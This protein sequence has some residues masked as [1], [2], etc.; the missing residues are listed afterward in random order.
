MIFDGVDLLAV[1]LDRRVGDH[2][3]GVERVLVG[4]RA[5]GRVDIVDQPFVQR[6]GVHAAFPVV[7]DGV[8]ETVDLGL[9]V[10]DARRL[11]GFAGG[12]ERLG[13]GLG[14]QRV[15]RLVERLGGR[16]RVLVSGERDVGIGRDHRLRIGVGG[17]R[18]RDERGASACRSQ[19][20]Q[21]SSRRAQAIGSV[22]LFL[23][24][25]KP[26]ARRLKIVR[27]GLGPHLPA[28]AQAM[29][30]APRLSADRTGKPPEFLQSNGFKAHTSKGN[31]SK[32]RA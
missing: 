14:D 18:Q 8:A 11:P 1:D 10:G 28:T 30:S 15:G 2:I 22:H 4:L 5:V 32:A 27:A 9:L 25:E 7:D 19:R 12:G 16:Q 31:A 29:L 23:L 21:P 17:G 20:A 24:S 13:R 3:G 6:P 26:R